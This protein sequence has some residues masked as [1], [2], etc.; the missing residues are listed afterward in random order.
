MSK[1]SFL[2]ARAVASRLASIDTF[3]IIIDTNV[4]SELLKPRPDASVE[5]WF[6]SMRPDDLFI[7]S[8]VVAELS[9]GAWLLPQ[10]R[11]R[12]ALHA[13]IATVFEESYRDRTLAFDVN[14][15]VHYGDI[16][17]KR[18]QIGR[19][20]HA[21]D[22]QIAAIARANSMAVA[23]RNTKDFEGCGI[24]LIDPWSAP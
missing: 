14:T 6:E 19:P 12:K 23:T 21:L 15:A 11:R 10:G 7:T 17:A 8:I 16:R 4:V 5:A 9:F 2:R 20:I 3:V 18:Q 13:A 1:S 24:A 22:A